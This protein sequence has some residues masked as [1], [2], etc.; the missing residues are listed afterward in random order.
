MQN[1][2]AVRL[3]A[4]IW[5]CAMMQTAVTAHEL[6][7]LQRQGSTLAHQFCSRCHATGQLGSSPHHDAPPFRDLASD[8]DLDGFA[9]RLREGLAVGHPDMPM[10]RFSRDNAR[11]LTAYLRAVQGR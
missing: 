4:L 6:S 2:K 10:F 3:T 7:A 11:A 8:V 9:G 1:H 5:I